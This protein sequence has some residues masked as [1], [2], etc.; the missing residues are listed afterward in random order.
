MG[1]AF[2]LWCIIGFGII[3]CMTGEGVII[4]IPCFLLAAHLKKEFS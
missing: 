3:C 2:I 4:G 1:G